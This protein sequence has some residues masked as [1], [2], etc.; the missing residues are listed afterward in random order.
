MPKRSHPN[1]P[2][3]GSH[4]NLAGPLAP[5]TVISTGAAVIEVVPIYGLL[6]MR[7]RVKLSAGDGTLTFKYVRPN[8]DPEPPGFLDDGTSLHTTNNPSDLAVPD[9]VSE[10]GRDIDDL[11]GEAFL[12]IEFTDTSGGSTI[13]HITVAGV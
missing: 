5:G 2:G 8:V 7:I 12:Q 3:L 4:F 13:G 6:R 10:V 9:A 11:Y 1:T